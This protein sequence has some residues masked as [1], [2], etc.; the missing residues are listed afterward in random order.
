MKIKAAK[1]NLL[2]AIQ[3]TQNV[4]SIK[5]TL[6]ILSN[7]LIETQKDL[8]KLMSNSVQQTGKFLP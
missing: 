6:P 7:I 5:T 4:I 1:E 3:T 2:T 8:L